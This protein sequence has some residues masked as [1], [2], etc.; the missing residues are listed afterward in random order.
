MIDEKKDL[1]ELPFDNDPNKD[2]YKS[3]ELIT[4]EK[5]NRTVLFRGNSLPKE[6]FPEYALFLVIKEKII[7]L[8]EGSYKKPKWVKVLS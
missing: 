1:F 8:N 4:S 5:M 3:G 6:N 7:Y 2:G